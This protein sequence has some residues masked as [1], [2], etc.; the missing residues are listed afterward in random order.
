M[1]KRCYHG[2]DGEIIH[3]RLDRRGSKEFP[4][5]SIT[6]GPLLQCR[7]I[8]QFLFTAEWEGI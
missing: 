2:S 5:V 3:S 4:L 6:S 7:D 8:F 1:T